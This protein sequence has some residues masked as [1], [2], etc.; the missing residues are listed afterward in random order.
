M[1]RALPPSLARLLPPSLPGSV[2]RPPPPLTH[3]SEQYTN[4]AQAPHSQKETFLVASVARPV[5]ASASPREEAARVQKEGVKGSLC[6]AERGLSS[7][8]QSK[9]QRGLG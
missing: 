6:S 4:G 8:F 7:A 1:L 2:K 9:Q 3:C 5:A